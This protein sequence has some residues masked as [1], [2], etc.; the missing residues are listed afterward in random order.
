M[1]GRILTRQAQFA[2]KIETTEGTAETLAAADAAGVHANLTDE[3]GPEAYE[4]NASRPGLDSEPDIKGS[5]MRKFSG[6]TQLKGGGASSAAKW[7][8]IIQACGL[9]SVT[10]LKVFSV[11]TITSGP[12]TL[13]MRIGN[14]AS[15]GSATKTGVVVAQLSGPNRLVIKPVT[16][17][18]TNGD[19][20]FG[21]T[22]TTP[23]SSISSTLSAAG[24]AFELQTE[25]PSAGP[26]SVTAEERDGGQIFRVV[27]ARGDFSLMLEMNKPALL[28]WEF[29]GCPVLQNDASELTGSAFANV[30]TLGAPPPVCKGCELAIDGTALTTTTI[31]QVE[32][33][34]GNTISPD[35]TIASNDF[36]ASGNRGYVITDRKPTLSFD[37]RR[38]V[39]G[40]NATGKLYGGATFSASAKVGNTSDTHGQVI[41]YAPAAQVSGASEGD[42]N[43]MRTD[44]VEAKLTGSG[45]NAWSLYHVFAA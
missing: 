20:I 3:R 28:K 15:E 17:T 39:P 4:Q 25:S 26:P 38:E 10:G 29:T 1:P 44:Q 16:G 31:T 9:S 19:S 14:N 33:K 7:H 34:A 45:D 6:E 8:E 24:W 42:R 23:S 13:G 2:I 5:R 37:P 18:F 22:G 30:S 35:E 40:I 32:L 43:G 12:F 41:A 27:G 36:A 21:Y 11:G